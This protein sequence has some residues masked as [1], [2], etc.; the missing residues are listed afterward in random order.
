MSSRANRV[1]F[2]VVILVLQK[3]TGGK[4]PK[5]FTC[6]NSILCRVQKWL[7]LYHFLLAQLLQSTPG[8]GHLPRP[9]LAVCV[10]VCAVASHHSCLQCPGKS[11]CLPFFLLISLPHWATQGRIIAFT[12]SFDIPTSQHLLYHWP[13]NRKTISATLG[14]FFIANQLVR[15]TLFKGAVGIR[16][17]TEHFGKLIITFPSWNRNYRWELGRMAGQRA[18][19][20]T[21]L[22]VLS[23][24]T[25]RKSPNNG[26]RGS[27][28][29]PSNET[30]LF[31]R[32]SQE[33][34]G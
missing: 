19:A 12:L 28:A 29:W 30:V 33:T 13:P 7:L 17:W 14:D 34:Q 22:P 24:E 27:W 8:Q 5:H 1:A 9:A 3:C 15:E 16:M 2:F 20:S 4:L 25:N 31:R 21:M 32:H 11:S 6:L 26:K 18:S 23:A 10:Q